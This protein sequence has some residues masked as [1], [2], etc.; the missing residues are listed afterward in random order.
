VFKNAIEFYLIELDNVLS[1][2]SVDKKYLQICTYLYEEI[3][4][5]SNFQSERF[6]TVLGLLGS[7]LGYSMFRKELL[8]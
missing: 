8:K 3:I 7:P 1:N 5:C 2:G 6:V 4:K